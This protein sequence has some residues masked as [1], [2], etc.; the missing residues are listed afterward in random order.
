LRL[1]TGIDPLI[2][3]KVREFVLFYVSAAA[4]FIFIAVSRQVQQVRVMALEG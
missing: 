1:G 4:N 2:A 3:R